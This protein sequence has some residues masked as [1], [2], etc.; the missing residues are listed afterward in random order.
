MNNIDINKEEKI[1]KIGDQSYRLIHD[2]VFVSCNNFKLSA[3]SLPKD[4]I[5]Y[6]IFKEA[7]LELND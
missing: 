6:D 3:R 5:T 4:D 2:R 1:I 7:L